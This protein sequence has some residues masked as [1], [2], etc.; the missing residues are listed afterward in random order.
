MKFKIDENLPVEI[1]ELLQECGHDAM[2]VIEQNLSGE[3]D[4]E[5]ALICQKE[6][7]SIV[8]LDLDFSDIRTYPPEKYHGIIVMRLKRQDKPYIINIFKGLLDF[9]QREPLE[10]NLWIVEEEKIR[11]RS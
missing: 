9:L 1:A 8:T 10:R 11:I 5:I 6:E 3:K 4:P 2:T 7:R